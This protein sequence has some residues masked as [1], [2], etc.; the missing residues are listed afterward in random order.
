[1]PLLARLAFDGGPTLIG[2]LFT[3]GTAGC[4]AGTL[5]FAAR[6]A[7]TPQTMTRTTLAMSVALLAT[8]LAPHELLA[9]PGLV[10]L[11]F[12]WSYL[13]SGVIATLQT[14]EP[15]LM[16][17]VMSLFAVVLLGGMTI[18]G[19]LTTAVTA[20][21]GPRAPFAFGA[22]AALIAAAVLSSGRDDPPP[23]HG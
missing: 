19:P 18:G 3:A 9:L 17:R 12:T 20:I 22:I 1:V 4:L 10:G 11:G 23:G 6:G 7:P 5:A 16:G 21:A 15:R 13:L 14:A 8:A 2:A